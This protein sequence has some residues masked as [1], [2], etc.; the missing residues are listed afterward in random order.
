ML[1]CNR[2]FILSHFR[3]NAPHTYWGHDLDLS[4]SCDVIGHVTNQ[5][6]RCHFLLVSHWNRIS[7]FNR[8]RDIRPPIPVRTHQ[9]RHTHAASDF[10]FCP[11]QRI[12]LD[13]QL[14]Q[15]LLSYPT[16]IQVKL[17]YSDSVRR[18]TK[19]IR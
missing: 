11:M 10:I 14:F 9:P 16:F 15:L 6:A 19:V 8:F 18:A 12:A 17:L 7:I 4:R 5:S 3:D 13:R 2:A 1:Y